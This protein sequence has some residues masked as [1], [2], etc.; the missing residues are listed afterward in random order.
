MHGN[1]DIYSNE[2]QGTI[3]T[4]SLPLSLTIAQGE[5]I[6]KMIAPQQTPKKISG[7]ALVIDDETGMRRVLKSYLEMYGLEVTEAEDGKEALSILKEKS[8]SYVFVD[9]HMPRMD[10][11]QLLEELHR[12]QAVGTADY[13]FMTGGFVDDVLTPELKTFV[14]GFLNKPFTEEDLAKLLKIN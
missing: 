2:G 14:K 9:H 6:N 8:F 4:I 7:A 5:A 12:S 1:I 11:A 10:G 13:F 3:V